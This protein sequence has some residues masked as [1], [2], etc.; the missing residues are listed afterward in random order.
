MGI[1]LRLRCTTRIYKLTP[2]NVMDKGGHDVAFTLENYGERWVL[3]KKAGP[4]S[5][6]TTAVV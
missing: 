3:L 6:P 5:G 2:S 1:T 4:A